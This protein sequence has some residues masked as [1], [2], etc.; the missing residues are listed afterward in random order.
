MSFDAT[1]GRR[2]ARRMVA[3]AVVSAVLLAVVYLVAV[4]TEWGQRID[5]AALDGRTTR[6]A[7]QNATSRLLDTISIA[8]LALGSAAIVVI[9]LMRR[10]PHLALDAVEL[11]GAYAASIAAIA[12]FALVLLLAVLAS[13]RG[14]SLDPPQ[15]EQAGRAPSL[16]AT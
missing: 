3:L 6:V 11:G 14:L 5:D 8:S 16:A 2:R 15:H 1:L 13:L 4:H 12:G 10:R 9:A 7:V